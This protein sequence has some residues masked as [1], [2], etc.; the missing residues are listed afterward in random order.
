MVIEMEKFV[1]T[2]TKTIC[3]RHLVTK[4]RMPL[5]TNGSKIIK[6]LALNQLD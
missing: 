3:I 2:L 4:R 6:L 1:D 5:K